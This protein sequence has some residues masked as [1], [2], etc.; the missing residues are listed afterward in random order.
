MVWSQSNHAVQMLQPM[1]LIEQVVAVEVEMYSPAV[2]W[3]QMVVVVVEVQ[4]VSNNALGLLYGHGI[5][6]IYENLLLL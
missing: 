3:V 6:T 5:L 1:G 2:L 4:Y